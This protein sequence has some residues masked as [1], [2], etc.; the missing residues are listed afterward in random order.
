MAGTAPADDVSDFIATGRT[1]RRNAVPDIRD[2]QQVAT[3]DLPDVLSKLS[4]EDAGAS[5]SAAG[6]GSAAVGGAAGGAAATT[7]P[8]DGEAAA[9]D[10]SK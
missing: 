3:G 10:P 5:T 6:S 4:C 8:S 2:D 9:A 7:K 1:G